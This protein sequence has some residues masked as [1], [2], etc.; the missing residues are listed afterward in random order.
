MVCIECQQIKV[1]KS[2]KAAIE[3][4]VEEA[5][6]ERL[7]RS[8]HKGF[9]LLL[10]LTSPFEPVSSVVA[11]HVVRDSISGIPSHSPTPPTES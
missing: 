6:K 10:D 1:K 4:E 11:A 2:D 3:R 9:P 7:V 5:C 8:G